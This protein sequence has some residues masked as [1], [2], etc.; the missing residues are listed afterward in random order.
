MG[1]ASMDAP[2]PLQDR[3]VIL[4]EHLAR[5]DGPTICLIVAFLAL[6]TVLLCSI[7]DKDA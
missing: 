5:I 4:A 7:F 2:Q 1:T 6:L 3:R